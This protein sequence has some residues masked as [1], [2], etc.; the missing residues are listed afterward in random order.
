MVERY[1]QEVPPEPMAPKNHVYPGIPPVEERREKSKDDRG[2]V[3]LYR[4]RDVC[5]FY[6]YLMLMECEGSVLLAD[7]D[8]DDPRPMLIGDEPRPYA[9][10]GHACLYP[11]E[12]SLCVFLTLALLSPRATMHTWLL[13]AQSLM[14]YEGLT[15]VQ[16]NVP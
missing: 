14:R 7:D 12:T 15:L 3:L 4:G 2:I 6:S 9:N 1:P 10:M 5:C 11:C 16:A 8:D 13:H